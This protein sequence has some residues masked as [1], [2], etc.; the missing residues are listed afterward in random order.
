MC[1][2][3]TADATGTIFSQDANEGPGTKCR[4]VCPASCSPISKP[5]SNARPGCTDPTAS[6]SARS[7]GLR[8]SCGRLALTMSHAF[9]S[10]WSRIVYRPV[11]H[12]ACRE[13]WSRLPRTVSRNWTFRWS[14]SYHPGG[15]QSGIVRSGLR[16]KT[17]PRRSPPSLRLYTRS[18]RAWPRSSVWS[19]SI[20]LLQIGF[21]NS[22]WFSGT[23]A[24][25][26]LISGIN[27]S[28]VGGR[29]RQN[30]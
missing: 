16:Q 30:S 1:W 12:L 24:C 19:H 6:R 27:G 8:N 9:V 15:V 26:A 7:T 14:L 11:P 3:V 18:T 2:V 29:R 20:R 4:T 21:G 22:H 28:R 5:P 25:G 13:P 17:W 10:S 23:R